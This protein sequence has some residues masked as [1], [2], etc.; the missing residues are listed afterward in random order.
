MDDPS[1]FGTRQVEDSSTL[2]ASESFG[3]FGVEVVDF[4]QKEQQEVEREKSLLQ[5]RRKRMEDELER[6]RLRKGYL[7]FPVVYPAQHCSWVSWCYGRVWTPKTRTPQ[8][9]CA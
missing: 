7:W 2:R 6:L 3:S 8:C 1:I 4:L 5:E 9:C